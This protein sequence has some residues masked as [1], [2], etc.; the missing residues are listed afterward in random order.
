[1]LAFTVVA[2]S[3][4]APATAWDAHEISHISNPVAIDEHHHHDDDRVQASHGH[5]DQA[6]AQDDGGGHDHMPSLAAALSAIPAN[7]PIAIFPMLVGISPPS[8]AAKVPVDLIEPPP[9]RP[10][11]SV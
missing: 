2:F 8:F 1:M 11:R 9:A 10:P 5:G 3:M 4:T 7:G 6:P